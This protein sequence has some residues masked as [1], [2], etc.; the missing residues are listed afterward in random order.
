MASQ[1]LSVDR[2]LVEEAK[3]LLGHHRIRRVRIAGDETAIIFGLCDCHQDAYGGPMA[4]I[5]PVQPEQ[6]YA[7]WVDGME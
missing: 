1:E 7:C 6:C 4:I 3:V 5:V 2:E